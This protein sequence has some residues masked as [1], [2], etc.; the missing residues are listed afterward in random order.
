MIDCNMSVKLMV[1][2]VS[3]Y[4]IRGVSSPVGM[5]GGNADFGPT[6]PTKMHANKQKKPKTI[7][8]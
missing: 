1:G 8:K 4:P 3:T 7:N 2:K 5:K 6:L